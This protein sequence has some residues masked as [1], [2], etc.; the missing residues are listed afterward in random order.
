MPADMSGAQD[1][2]GHVGDRVDRGPGGDDA[3]V[4]HQR[5]EGVVGDLRLGRRQHRDERGLPRAG[6]S[7]QRH[8]RDGLQLQDDVPEVPRLA[9]QREP[10]GLAARGGEGG[11]AEP[12][13]SALG[14]DVG[15]A[16]PDQVGEDVARLVE[17]DGAVRHGQHQV[18]TVLAAAVAALAGLAVGGLAVRGVVVVEERRHGLVDGE[19]HIP[20]ASA[21]AAVGSAERLELLTVDG[22]TAVASV[23]RGDMQLDAVHEGGHG[24]VPPETSYGFLVLTRERRTRLPAG[25][26]RSASRKIRSGD[27]NDVHD[28]AAAAGAELDGTRQQR[29]QRV[30]AATAHA[31]AGV[32]VGAA[33]TDQDLT[34]ADDL[35]AEALHAEPLGIRVA[36]VPGGRCALLV[37]HLSSVPYF[38]AAGILVTLIAV[39]CWRW[40]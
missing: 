2:T 11:V 25:E 15:G 29:E 35:T 13:A 4:G 26:V 1:K 27:R 16:L 20:A 22:G 31:R 19:D 14:G 9:E 24:E 12:A 6:I 34:R 40:P 10:G 23:T 37:C 32:E 28:L 17:D 3:E 36:T 5:G 7:D 39:Y 30:V 21:V 8:V 18:L 33:L 38:A